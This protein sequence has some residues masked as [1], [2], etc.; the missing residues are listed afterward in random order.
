LRAPAGI[1]HDKL[2]AEWTTSRDRSCAGDGRAWWR[3]HVSPLHQLSYHHSGG[4]ARGRA[5]GA[6]DLAGKSAEFE[7]MMANTEI[8]D[9]RQPWL[10]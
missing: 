1:G 8:L 2:A 9:L 7:A 4:G 5:E 3:L 6:A 10:Y